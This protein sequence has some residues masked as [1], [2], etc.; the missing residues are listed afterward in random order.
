MVIPLQIDGTTKW[1]CSSASSM[2]L[3][4]LYAVLL[5]LARK[6]PLPAIN[7]LPKTLLNTTESRIFMYYEYSDSPLQQLL[8]K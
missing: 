6:Q 8:I 7:A 3:K 1:N 4:A 5:I 2:G